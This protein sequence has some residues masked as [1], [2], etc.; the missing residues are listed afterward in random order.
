MC[1]IV[2]RGGVVGIECHGSP[3]ERWIASM[4]E[5]QEA[6]FAEI[7]R[8]RRRDASGERAILRDLEVDEILEVR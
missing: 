5:G 6:D 7:E 3:E 8:Q 2:V 4:V 1:E